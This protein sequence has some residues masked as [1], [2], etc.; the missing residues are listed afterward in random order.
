MEAATPV[1][2][3]QALID[4]IG[5]AP[6]AELVRN[7]L[8]VNSDRNVPE[9]IRSLA[10]DAMLVAESDSQGEFKTKEELL[11]KLQELLAKSVTA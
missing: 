6:E 11:E 5:V 7:F 9:E 4:Q 8:R 10:L 1:N 3:L 2:R